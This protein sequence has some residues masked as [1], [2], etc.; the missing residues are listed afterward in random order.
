MVFSFA[1]SCRLQPGKFQRWVAVETETAMKLFVRGMLVS[2]RRDGGGVDGGD[3]ADRS[4][5]HRHV[6]GPCPRHDPVL[7]DCQ[8]LA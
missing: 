1:R 8:T 4:S 6:K 7:T 3:V 2:D 5:R